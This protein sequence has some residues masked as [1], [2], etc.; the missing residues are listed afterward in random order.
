MNQCALY[1]LAR[2]QNKL[3]LIT[4]TMPS[5]VATCRWRISAKESGMTRMSLTNIR[6]L[7]N[8]SIAIIQTGLAFNWSFTWERITRWPSSITLK[9]SISKTRI[10]RQPIPLQARPENWLKFQIPQLLLLPLP[11]QLQAESSNGHFHLLCPNWKSVRFAAK[12]KLSQAC[13]FTWLRTI[14]PSSWPTQGF[15]WRRLS[16]VL[17]VLILLK[18]MKAC[19]STFWSSTSTW[20]PWQTRSRIPTSHLF[21]QRLVTIKYRHVWA[22]D[23]FHLVLGRWKQG[24]DHSPRLQ[25]KGT[26]PLLALW[27][28]L[29]RWTN[30]IRLPQTFMWGSFPWTS[31]VR[32]NPSR[33]QRNQQRDQCGDD[34]AQIPLSCSGL[35]LRAASKM[36]HGQ[37]LRPQAS[38]CQAILRQHLQCGK[39]AAARAAN[40][41]AAHGSRP[42]SPTARTTSAAAS[43]DHQTG[44]LWRQRKV[45][46]DAP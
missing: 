5:F 25:P 21:L 31:L 9:F 15:L 40:A 29:M 2:Y 32:H 38:N 11:L 4:G 6:G 37:A 43:T 42:Q 27:W 8:A 7:S 14:S 3:W 41:A 12:T 26:F 30:L 45:A 18:I 33:N 22:V 24:F 17:Y 36:G 28:N 23:Y 19:S 34:G 20:I 44:D 1:C 35:R 39:H 13:Y 10:G 46:S 16:S